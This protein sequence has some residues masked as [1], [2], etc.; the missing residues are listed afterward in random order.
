MIKVECNKGEMNLGIEGSGLT[1]MS[2]LCVIVDRVCDAMAE[3]EEDA[4]EY[5]YFIMMQVIS[6]LKRKAKE[7]LKNDSED[8]D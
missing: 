5:K 7:E 4:K 1:I 8:N 3:D 2:E 6:A